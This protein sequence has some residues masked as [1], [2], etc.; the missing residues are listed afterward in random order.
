MW[1]RITSK[2]CAKCREPSNFETPENVHTFASLR[3]QSGYT[4][5]KTHLFS[6]DISPLHFF[7]L[8]HSP[9]S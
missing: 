8:H 2:F 7:E 9:Q 3:R 1:S 5:K 4:L 6:L